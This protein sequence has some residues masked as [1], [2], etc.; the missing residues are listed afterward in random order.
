M[1][2]SI[3]TWMAAA[4][5]A[6]L[7]AAC[8]HPATNAHASADTRDSSASCYDS[9]GQAFDLR[10]PDGRPIYVDSPHAVRVRN[11]T[12]LLGSPTFIWATPDAFPDSLGN[13]P[14]GV[15]PKPLL[16]AV[17]RSDG[18]IA[19][20]PRP[21]IQGPL[22]EV[23]VRQAAQGSIDVFFGTPP[24][25]NPDD[26]R[27]TG[28]IWRATFDGEQWSTPE[29]VLEGDDISW[30][31]EPTMPL[32]ASKGILHVAAKVHDKSHFPAP[33]TVTLYARRDKSGWH[34]RWFDLGRFGPSYM[35][36]ATLGRDSIGLFFLGNVGEVAEGSRALAVMWSSDGGATWSAPRLIRAIPSLGEGH[37]LRAAS[38]GR[39]IH[40]FWVN[41]P[42]M[43][44]GPGAGSTIEHLVTT[45]GATW[46]NSAPLNFPDALQGYA[47]SVR[48]GG[49]IDILSQGGS[50]GGGAIS[51]STYRDSS[52][53]TVSFGEESIG[54]ASISMPN[55]DSVYVIWGRVTVALTKERP[56]I[57][58]MLRMRLGVLCSN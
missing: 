22:R 49:Q 47:I 35:D 28:R 36:F 7:D 34:S 42:Y 11:G 10:L 2:T 12:A 44:S 21:N 5:L 1:R 6:L 45:D 30:E 25:N 9:W 24:R 51:L 19:P 17:L 3:R 46:R 55:A 56:F 50:G 4:S 33:R 58:P 57:A 18:T 8:A 15:D 27:N 48:R 13:N 20:I 41:G 32:L 14:T 53:T 38:I 40:L 39:T 26:A 37:W 29:L 31:G 23:I 52:W 16:G 54:R 43:I